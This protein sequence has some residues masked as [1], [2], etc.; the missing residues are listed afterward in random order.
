MNFRKLNP[1]TW[2]LLISGLVLAITSGFLSSAAFT[3]V[4][5]ERV[6]LDNNGVFLSTLL[7]YQNQ[8]INH[9]RPAILAY[10]GWGGA[11][12][13]ILTTCLDFAKAGYIVLIPDLRG[14]GESGGISTLGRIEQADARIAIDYLIS[15]TDLVNTSALSVWGTSFGGLISLLA[16]GNDPRILATVVASA[17]ANTTAWLEERDFRWN[18]RLTF[19]P[20]TMI[21]PK[22][23]SAVEERSPMTNIHNIENLLVMHGD[24]DTLV[25]VHHAYDL[26][27]ASNSS[28]KKLIIFPNEGHNLDWGRVKK[29]TTQFLSEVFVNPNTKIIGMSTSFLFL[30]SSWSVLLIGALFATMGIL[31]LFP[32]IQQQIY[33]R[34]CLT[35]ST[36]K[37]SF[38]QPSLIGLVF[39][40]VA[41][42][43]L[44]IASA[45]TSLM[46]MT[47]H[48]TL[49]GLALSTLATIGLLAIGIA[50][51][52]KHQ[53]SL[54]S[55]KQLKKW[56]FESGLALGMILGIYIGWILIADQP[57]IPFINLETVFRLSG[58]LITIGTFLT[59]ETL[60]FW[61]LIHQFVTKLDRNQNGIIYISR[62]S[63]I[64]LVT[65]CAIFFSLISYWYLLGIRLI[66]SGI[67]LFGPVG[68][69][70]AIVRHKWGFFPTLIFTVLAGL[71]AFSTFSVFFLLI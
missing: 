22:N 31:S 56:T 40:L 62:M 49:I 16:A 69:I 45:I 44:H 20:Y 13:S 8:P 63:L 46:I 55:N 71:T 41:F 5:I 30:L 67:T 42:V 1:L 4:H 68:T 70:S 38:N 18:E 48:S 26:I 52:Q 6:Q 14:H 24:Q 58:I 66:V 39:L 51:I 33:T 27:Q 32:I 36:T 3:N 37:S 43:I 61:G 34:W 19:R 57:W 29:E 9:P 7:L 53:L 28:N 10:H 15:R 2:M 11:K 64:Y 17:P 60:F 65:K 21:D 12:E 35:K 23:L 47:F 50:M 59:I 25:P 54:P